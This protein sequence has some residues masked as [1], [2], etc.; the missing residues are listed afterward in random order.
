MTP[1]GEVG[2]DLPP[3]PPQLTEGLLFVQRETFGRAGGDV[4]NCGPAIGDIP[5]RLA[6][7]LS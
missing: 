7:L 4:L 2:R 6:S 3:P 1:V 5:F